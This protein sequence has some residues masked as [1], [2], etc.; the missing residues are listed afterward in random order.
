MPLGFLHTHPGW[1]TGRQW[2]GRGFRE[3]QL[4]AHRLWV[5]GGFARR[6][7]GLLWGHSL[8]PRHHWMRERVWSGPRLW[9]GGCSR[10]LGAGPH[11]H[12]GAPGVS[13]LPTPSC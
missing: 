8:G 12:S 6:P 4:D 11:A 13:A 9:G 2:G 10:G 5:P 1:G 3:P 7:Q